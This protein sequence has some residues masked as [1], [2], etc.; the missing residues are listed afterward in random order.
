M[1]L[2]VWLVLALGASS[3]LAGRPP[4]K[5]PPAVR[6]FEQKYR[7]AHTLRADFLELYRENG[8]E[9]RSEAGTAYF[10]RPGKMRWE[11]A[12]PEPDLFVIDGKWSWFYVPSDHAA[13]RIRARDSADWRTPFA[14]LAG[15]MKVSRICQRVEPDPTQRA[16][17]PEG[18]VFRCMLRGSPKETEKGAGDASSLF[19]SRAE[20]VLFELNA[21][22]GEL[23]RIVASDPG[24]VTI[25]FRFA[26]WQFDPPVEP[27]KFHFAP[28]RGVA[29][30]DG[31][32]GYPS[33]GKSPPLSS[34]SRN[35]K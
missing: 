33:Q 4:D 32:L 28:Q 10:G 21:T 22:T 3:P 11:Y 9:V 14:L 13:T 1:K 27:S 34:L 30:V 25:E 16:V 17:S 29:I 23:F 15:E 26:N 2:K 8:R 24:G 20:S 18:A 19:D 31:D 12:S 7:A 35:S 6:L 5:W